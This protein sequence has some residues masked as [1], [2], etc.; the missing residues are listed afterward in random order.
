MLRSQEKKEDEGGCRDFRD[1]ARM[2]PEGK[3]KRTQETSEG[4]TP[5]A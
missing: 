1:V 3:N 4:Q 2:F 5:R